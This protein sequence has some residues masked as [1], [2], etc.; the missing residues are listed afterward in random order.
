MD[1]LRAGANAGIGIAILPAFQCVEDLRTRK[2]ERVLRD[3]DVPS[4]PIHVVYPTARYITPKVRAFVE[5]LQQRM[6]PPPWELGPA[7]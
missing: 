5:H 6:T 2:L 3:W 4:T 7:P 1:I